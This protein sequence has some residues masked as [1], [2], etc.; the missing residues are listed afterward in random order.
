[1]MIKNIVFDMGNVLVQYAPAKFVAKF[2]DNPQ[3]QSLLLQEIFQSVEWIQFDRGT[4]TK[5]EMIQKISKRN[6]EALEGIIVD[7][8]ENWHEE[9]QPLAAMGKIV[10][11][12]K[13]NGYHLFILSNAPVDYYQFKNKVPCIELFDGV[14]ISSDWKQLKPDRSDPADSIKTSGEQL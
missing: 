10:E 5:A 6:P 1:M 11:N 2:A 8:I 3:T 9:L 13:Q 7:I 4:I 14:F 12:L